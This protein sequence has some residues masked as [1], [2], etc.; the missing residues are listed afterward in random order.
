MRAKSFNDDIGKK[1]KKNNKP[2]T[3]KSD[4]IFQS[5]YIL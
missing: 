1:K 4:S 2:M 3:L 5:I